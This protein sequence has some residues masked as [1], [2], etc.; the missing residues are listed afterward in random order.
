MKK[1]RLSIVV[2]FVAAISLGMMDYETEHVIQLFDKENIAGLTIIF[3][4]CSF[5]SYLFLIVF[6]RHLRVLL[7]M[8]GM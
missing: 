7:R 1:I 4:I 3:L 5:V 6:G 2:G 8:L